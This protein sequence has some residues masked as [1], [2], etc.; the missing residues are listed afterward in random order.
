MKKTFF[1]IC[2]FLFFFSY[3]SLVSTKKHAKREYK[4]DDGFKERI[5]NIIDSKGDM[6]TQERD[7]IFENLKVAGGKDQ[8]NQYKQDEIKIEEGLK[9]D[10]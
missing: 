5:L 1:T 7:K 3:F 10:L 6:T 4:V 8:K 2:F 9:S